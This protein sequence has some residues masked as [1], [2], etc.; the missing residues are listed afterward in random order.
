MDD[1][2]TSVLFDPQQTPRLTEFASA[3]LASAFTVGRADSTEGVEEQ[4]APPAV[5]DIQ[6]P[7]GNVTAEALPDIGAIVITG[8]TPGNPSTTSS[9][10]VFG[11][12]PKFAAAFAQPVNILL[13]VAS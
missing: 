10:S 13:A 7:H 11:A 1:R 9:T 5:G 12:E 8:N 4:Q 2:G 6:A 3:A